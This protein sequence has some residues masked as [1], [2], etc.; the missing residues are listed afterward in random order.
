MST[1]T[2]YARISLDATGEGAGVERQE[3][4]CRELCERSGWEVSEVLV[5]NSISATSGKL[6]PAFERL[7]E[8]KP[9]RI[10]CWHLDRLVRL[11]PELERVL[12]LSVDVHTVAGGKLDLS[13]PAGRAVARTVTAWATYETEQKGERQRSAHEQR[14]RQGR[15][16]WVRRPFGY[17]MD[18]TLRESEAAL[19]RRAYAQVLEG[20][21]IAGIARAWRE[22]GVR[23]TETRNKPEGGEFRPTTVRGLLIHPR[24]IGKLTRSEGGGVH[25]ELDTYGTWAPLVDEDTFRRVERELTRPGRRQAASTKRTGLLTGLLF[26]ASC[27]GAMRVFS[28]TQRGKTYRYYCCTKRCNAWPREWL[29]EHLSETALALLS[30]PSFHPAS[31]GEGITEEVHAAR[32]EV[33]RLRGLVGELLEDR[34]EGLLTR[35][36]WR[37]EQAATTAKL[38]EVEG[39][40]EGLER[41]RGGL[42]VDKL[43]REGML[44]WWQDRERG[45]DGRRELLRHLFGAITCAPRGRGSKAKP[46]RSL[47]AFERNGWA[48]DLALRIITPSTGEGDPEGE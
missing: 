12:E 15:P 13:N 20:A 24:N 23:T 6:R 26:C 19:L 28:Q 36:Q 7:L 33:E 47:L 40:L 8:S 34:R 37:T 4:E 30:S 48:N 25:T 35:E 16:F 39:K 38:A 43:D 46:D 2:I 29:D 18:G 11:T 14:R 17:N 32:A 5:D 10:V 41:G 21:S 31:E 3:R 22:A 27:D 9:E 44:A 45:Q 42:A 1:A